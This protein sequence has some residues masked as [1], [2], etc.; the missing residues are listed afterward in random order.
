MSQPHQFRPLERYSAKKTIKPIN[1]ICVA[2]D[3]KEVT[4]MGD[5][6]DWNPAA[7][8]LRRQPDGAWVGQANLGAGH[9]HYLFLVDG[10]WCADPDCTLRVPNP[11]GGQNMVRQVA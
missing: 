9:H 8:P 1:F 2:P 5:F 3:A 6:N 4:V 7:N 10:Q 11:Y